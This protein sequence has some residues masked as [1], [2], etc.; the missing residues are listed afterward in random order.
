MLRLS[1]DSTVRTVEYCREYCRKLSGYCQGFLTGTT[2][3]S[4]RVLSSTVGTVGT[5]GL[6]ELSELPGHCLGYCL[7]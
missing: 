4:C 5:V 3:H 7:T 6:S 2:L 1:Y